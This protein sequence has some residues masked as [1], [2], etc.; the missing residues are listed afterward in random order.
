M[1]RRSAAVVTVTS[2]PARF[3]T[4][5]THGRST[6]ADEVVRVME[7]LGFDEVMPWQRDV[8]EVA[9]EVDEAGELVYREVVL[10]VPRQAGKT[11]LLLALIVWRALMFGRPQVSW[12]TMQTR[13]HA[14]SKFVDEW[15]PILKGT[16]VAELFRERLALGSEAL[17]WSNGSIHSIGAP[18]KEAGHGGSIDQAL[19]DE[20]FALTDD[21]LEQGLKPTQITRWSPQT[22]IVSAAGDDESVYLK[23]KVDVG[24]ER[25]RLGQTT[26][27]CYFEWSAADDEDAA[28]PATW[29]SVH[30][31]VGHTIAEKA[32]ASDFETMELAEFERAYLC[33]WPGKRHTRVIAEDAWTRC[34]DGRSTPGETLCLAVDISPARDSAALVVASARADG[35]THVEITGTK[36]RLDHRPGT[37]WV[38]GRIVELVERHGIGTVGLDAGSAAGSLIPALEHAGVPLKVL[39]MRDVVRATGAFYDAAVEGRL[40]H[41]GQGPLDLAVAGAKKRTLADSWAWGRV[42]GTDICPLVASTL[43]HWLV[44]TGAEPAPK[45]LD[46]LVM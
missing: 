25:A 21:R 17:L 18:T 45:S 12:S 10:V 30:P 44:V 32:I 34:L 36:D 29:R 27:S 35:A 14:R 15:I 2:A 38:V 37:A 3:A 1:R 9:L 42:D 22:W 13:N 5:R 41:L 4:P 24:R 33:R 8:L 31:A 11:V 7:M 39:G 46:W 6:R 20:A 23:G 43:A 16:E 19:V 28:D 26:G 40:R